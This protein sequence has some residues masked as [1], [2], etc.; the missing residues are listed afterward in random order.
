VARKVQIQIRQL[1]I[2]KNRWQSRY[3]S[4]FSCLSASYW[5]SQVASF[6]RR[7]SIARTLNSSP[8]FSS[9]SNSTLPFSSLSDVT[10]RVSRSFSF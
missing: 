5:V 2:M 3:H 4:A 1:E 8:L 9:L 6:L 7:E 10:S